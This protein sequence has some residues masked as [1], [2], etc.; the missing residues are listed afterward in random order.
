MTLA[1]KAGQVQEVDESSYGEK[2]ETDADRRAPAVPAHARKAIFHA[3]LVA[4]MSRMLV[5]HLGEI[6]GRWY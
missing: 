5:M 1:D 3:F 4:P 2:E 6:H